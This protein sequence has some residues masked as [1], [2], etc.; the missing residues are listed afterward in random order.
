[1]IENLDL[2]RMEVVDLDPAQ[3]PERD[4]QPE[5]EVPEPPSGKN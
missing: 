2:F 4:P 5:P 1:M 3:N